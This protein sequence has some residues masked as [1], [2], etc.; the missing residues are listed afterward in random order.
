MRSAT[1][2]RRRRRRGWRRCWR[3]S[4]ARSARADEC[5]RAGR[6]GR[7][8]HGHVES[9]VVPAAPG[10]SKTQSRGALGVLRKLRGSPCSQP[11][12]SAPFW[13]HT[14]S[15][16]LR[17]E[18]NG[19]DM[20]PKGGPAAHPYRNFES[21]AVGSRV[22]LRLVGEGGNTKPQYKDA[23][24]KYEPF[25]EPGFQEATF[26]VP[27]VN[28]DVHVTEHQYVAWTRYQ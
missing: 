24:L 16:F 23:L 28:G 6:P 13:G 4:A 25:G 3:R 14:P 18:C 11:P 8:R 22:H 1:A 15:A 12:W 2:M 7:A 10:Y 19:L 26:S 20:S 9:D 17:G 21:I 27:G 5:R